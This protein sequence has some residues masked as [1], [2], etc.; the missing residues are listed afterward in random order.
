MAILSPALFDSAY[1]GMI[2]GAIPLHS[3]DIDKS[4][5]MVAQ[6]VLGTARMH[7]LVA[8]DRDNATVFYFAAPSSAF[9]SIPAF[10][11]PLAAALPGHPQHRGD[12]I[13]FLPDVSL[14]VAVEKTRDHIR[15]IANTPEVMADWLAGQTESAVYPVEDDEAWTMESIPAAYRRIADGISLSASRY[16]VVV[17]AIALLVYVGA[18]IG[19]S[20]LNAS[21]DK[22][23][24]AHMK[25]INNAV[26]R[27]DF[28]SPLSQQ[29]ARMQKVSALVVRAGG[30]IDEYRV[31]DGNEKFILM[32]PAWITRDYVD[33][34]GPSVVADQTS[35][36]NLIRIAQGAP[37]SGTTATP[38]G[39]TNKPV[40]VPR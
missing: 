40:V 17:A 25:A 35:D 16:C 36:D 28:V 30:W 5:F 4:V 26:T 15:L 33:A 13:Y 3:G 20:V 37:L 6:D 34:L 31:K 10:S 11:T 29:L 38:R 7:L 19:I 2:A 27:I 8:V 9:T 23:S 18:A 22:S 24:Q 1:A 39:L 21:A 12:G 14:S 32:M